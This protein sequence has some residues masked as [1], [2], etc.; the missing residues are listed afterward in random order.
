MKEKKL[1]KKQ[2]QQEIEDINDLLSDADCLY[3]DLK[4]A[5]AEYKKRY[6]KEY[7]Y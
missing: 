4:E 3:Y 7:E 2:L 6:G 1:T 5:Q